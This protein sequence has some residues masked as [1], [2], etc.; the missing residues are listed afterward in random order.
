MARWQLRHNHYLPVEGVF[1]EHVETANSTGESV[2]MRYPVPRYLDITDPKC[3]T[4][5]IHGPDGKPVDGKVV[6]CNGVGA[7]GRDIIY[8]GDPTPDMDPLDD[9]AREI[10]DSFRERWSVQSFDVPGQSYAEKILIEM[11][12]KSVDEA[13]PSKAQFNQLLEQNAAMIQALTRVAQSLAPLSE[14]E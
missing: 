12:S 4:E 9:E 8:K 14:E 13:Q 2:R 5:F 6:I 11:Q 10:S 1:Y 7:K 3:W